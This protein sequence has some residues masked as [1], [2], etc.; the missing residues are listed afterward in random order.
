MHKL[1]T[2]THI[3]GPSLLPWVGTKV[4]QWAGLGSYNMSAFTSILILLY[5]ARTNGYLKQDNG[6]IKEEEIN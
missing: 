3:H 6:R 5:K 2:I 1:V 4:I